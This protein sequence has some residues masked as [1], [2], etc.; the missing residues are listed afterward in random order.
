MSTIAGVDEGKLG[1]RGN[2]GIGKRP[3]ACRPI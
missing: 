3:K 2:D 1:R